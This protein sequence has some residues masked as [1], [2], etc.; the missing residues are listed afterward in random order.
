M[1]IQWKYSFLTAI[2]HRDI[3]NSSFFLLI[4]FPHSIWTFISLFYLD[5]FSVPLS[6]Q[7]QFIFNSISVYF[8]FNFSSI[9]FLFQ[10][11]FNSFSIRPRSHFGYLPNFFKRDLWLKN[12][13]LTRKKLFRKFELL[14]CYF[15]QIKHCDL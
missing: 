6:F 14:N 7:F 4:Y 12:G 13:Q 8:Q 11:C 9:S 5:L 3:R 10:F 2:L 1:E 15:C